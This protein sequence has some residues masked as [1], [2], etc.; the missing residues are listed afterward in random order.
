MSQ[1]SLENLLQW[2]KSHGA[3][4]DNVEF[5]L[6]DDKGVYGIL[7]HEVNFDEPLI[8]VPEALFIT[9]EMATEFFGLDNPVD[10]LGLLLLA[11]LKFDRTE[12]LINGNSLSK[13]YEPYIA[14]LPSTCLEIGLPLFWSDHEKELL[15]GTDAY[16]KLRQKREELFE[17]WRSLMSLL[18][19]KRPDLVME[20]TPLYKESRS[21]KSFEAYS[22]AYSIYCTRAFPNFLRKQSERSLNIGFLCP[23]VDL[24]NHKNGEK[25]TWSF[26]DNNFVFKSSAK[27]IKRG[28]EVYNNYGSKSNTELLLNYGFVLDGNESET[29]TLTLKVED[30]VIEAG[31]K[32]GLKLP[33][34]TSSSGLSFDLS[35]ATPLPK[36][37]IRFMGFLH[38]LTSEKNQ[39]TLRM[40]LEG[41]SKLRDILASRITTFKTWKIEENVNTNKKVIELVKRYRSSQKSLFQRAYELCDST[42]KS[43]IRKFKP[44]TLRK[45]LTLDPEFDNCLILIFGTNEVNE[46]EKKGFSDQVL[47]LFI[48]RCRNLKPARD[49]PLRFIHDTYENVSTT[50]E[51]TREDVLEYSDLY[52]SLFP[53]LSHKFPEIF[54]VGDYSAK[55]MIIAGTVVDRIVFKRKVNGELYLLRK[56]IL[57]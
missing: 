21:W 12:T 47:L 22:W 4:F 29:T 43:L 18:N 10:D 36:E 8:I 16:P 31:I 3:Y 19:E 24:L 51:I 42:E 37:L 53:Y 23:I 26:E 46:I 54:A 57:E 13:M 45:A 5:T 34:G 41:L 49:S 38:Q 32:F 44:L 14:F 2:S 39:Y 27:C 35:L 6:N 17:K 20:G 15:K 30:E 1:N 33:L 28:E 48:M 56:I 9:P 25:V 11:K 52:H 40:H 50:I 7:K 55:S